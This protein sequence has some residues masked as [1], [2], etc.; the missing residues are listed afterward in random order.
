MFDFQTYFN[1]L[2]FYTHLKFAGLC[3]H[4]ELVEVHRTHEPDPGCDHIKHLDQDFL[5]KAPISSFFYV[6]HYIK[7]KIT[8]STEN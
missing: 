3:V 4:R 2:F 1:I 5:H 6:K 7:F 8:K